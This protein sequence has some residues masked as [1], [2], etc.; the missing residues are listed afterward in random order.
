M[1]KEFDFLDGMDSKEALRTL[2]TSANTYCQ[3][4]DTQCKVNKELYEIILKDL[5]VLDQY[6]QLEQELG[7]PLAIYVKL[8][9]IVSVYTKIGKCKLL[10]VQSGFIVVNIDNK[11]TYLPLWEYTETW[12]LKEDKSE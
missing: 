1:S 11:T 10:K 3:H 5:E 4:N 6:K 9:K 12:W 8:H 2:R 7:C